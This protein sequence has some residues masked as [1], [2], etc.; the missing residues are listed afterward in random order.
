MKVVA[1][2]LHDTRGVGQRAKDARGLRAHADD[3]PLL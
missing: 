3:R 1:A 2:S